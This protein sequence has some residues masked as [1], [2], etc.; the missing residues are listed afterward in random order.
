MKTETSTK[1][2]ANSALK[3]AIKS[4][5]S[6]HALLSNMGRSDFPEEGM[7]KARALV[8]EISQRVHEFNAYNNVITTP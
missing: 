6:L 1:R 3:K 8:S 4:T 2:A 7:P 5:A